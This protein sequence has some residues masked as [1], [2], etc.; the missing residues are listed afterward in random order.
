MPPTVGEQSAYFAAVNW[1]KQSIVLDL[2]KR[3]GSEVLKRL[4]ARADVFVENFRPGVTDKLGVSWRMV[5]KINPRLVYVSVSA[6]GRKGPE[7]LRPGYDAVLQARTGLLSVTG[8]PGSPPVRVG[9]SI[10]DISSGMWGALGAL[11]ALYERESTGRGQ[12]VSAS[13]FKTGVSFLAYHLASLQMTGKLPT[14][15]GSEHNTFSPY[16]AFRVKGG[17]YVFIGVSNDRQFQRLATAVGR[18]EWISSP[19]FLKNKDRVANKHLL[20]KELERILPKEDP[21]IL[22]A[23]LRRAEHPDVGSAGCKGSPPRPPGGSD[24]PLR[25]RA[26]PR[27]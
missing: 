26:S 15:Q 12:H 27:G 1:Y 22:E 23:F 5:K 21:A 25:P 13:L 4:I 8:Y 17:R 11:T 18:P 19:R 7:R 14:P 9:V 16:G 10:L 3:E 2:K 6:Y 24:L 20:R